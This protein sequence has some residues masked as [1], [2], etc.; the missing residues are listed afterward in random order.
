MN[1]ILIG[2]WQVMQLKAFTLEM[3]EKVLAA[4]IVIAVRLSGMRNS[5]TMIIEIPDI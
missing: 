3:T 1:Q 5:N 2:L 4:G